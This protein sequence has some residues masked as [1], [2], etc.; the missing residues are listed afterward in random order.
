MPHLASVFLFLLSSQNPNQLMGRLDADET[1]AAS[2]CYWVLGDS[3][4]GQAGT[5]KSTYATCRVACCEGS[6]V[7]LGAI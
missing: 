7:S 1:F 5:G 2:I 3:S 6:F 4:H